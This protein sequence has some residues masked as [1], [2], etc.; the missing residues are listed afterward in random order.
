MVVQTVTNLRKFKVI[1]LDNGDGINP[2]NRLMQSSF[3]KQES[4]KIQRNVVFL[5]LKAKCRLNSTFFRRFIAQLWLLARPSL[6]LANQ[7]ARSCYSLFRP[8]LVVQ[9]IE[10]FRSIY[11]SI[12]RHFS[13]I[14][15]RLRSLTFSFSLS[16]E[17][18]LPY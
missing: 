17:E 16:C 3:V 2:S 1:I 4:G 13:A 8:L 14:R 10:P 7:Q 18:K 11:P 15:T 5:S 6:M 9:L 12:F